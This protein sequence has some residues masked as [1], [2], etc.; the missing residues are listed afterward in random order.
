VDPPDEV[1]GL[2]VEEAHSV[3]AKADNRFVPLT[4]N[5]LRHQKQL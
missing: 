3:L 1:R 5:N 2:I 4:A